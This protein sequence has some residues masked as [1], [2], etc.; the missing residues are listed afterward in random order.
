MNK[1]I[2]DILR[3]AAQD[4]NLRLDDEVITDTMDQFGTQEITQVIAMTLH[5]TNQILEPVL[6]LML[7]EFFTMAIKRQEMRDQW[8]LW[9]DD[10]LTAGVDANGDLVFKEVK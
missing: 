7:T 10:K 2:L 8:S 4:S 5:P 6:N 1:T 9:M 3:S